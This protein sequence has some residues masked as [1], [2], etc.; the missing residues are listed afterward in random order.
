MGIMCVFGTSTREALNNVLRNFGLGYVRNSGYDLLEAEGCCVQEG[1]GGAA[2]M[3][4]DLERTNQT[5]RKP[6][7]KRME[8]TGAS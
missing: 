2:G 8:Q 3:E 4:D 1:F 7:R 6:A 5:V